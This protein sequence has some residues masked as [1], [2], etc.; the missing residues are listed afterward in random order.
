MTTWLVTGASRGLGFGL[1]KKILETSKENTVFAT[2]RKP[3]DAKQLAEL[4]GSSNLFIVKLDVADEKSIAEASKEVESILKQKGLA[5]DFLINN[6]GITTGSDTPLTLKPK[7]FI[8]TMLTNVVGSML[9]AQHFMPYLEKAEKPVL[10]NMSSGRASIANTNVALQT[11]YSTSKAALDMLTRKLAIEKPDVISF[12]MAPGWVK[13]D[14][15]GPSAALEIDFS[16]SNMMKVLSNVSQKD[17][18]SFLRY[19]GSIVPW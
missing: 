15:G 17:S 6:A 8:D 14:M 11:S 10:M 3:D 19:D 16:V 12:A 9:V 7:N 4:A 1:V 13:T 18:G 2:C 5:L